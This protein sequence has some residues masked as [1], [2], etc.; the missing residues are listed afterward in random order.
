MTIIV[1]T[2]E[3]G[4]Y[5]TY[6]PDGPAF[7]YEQ[8]SLTSVKLMATV[9]APAY[10]VTAQQ[11]NSSGTNI[12]SA[13]TVNATALPVAVTGLV[14]GGIYNFKIQGKN[15]SQLGNSQTILQYKLSSTSLGGT[16]ISSGIDPQ[17]LTSA[18][19]YFEIAYPGGKKNEFAVA[20]KSFDGVNTTTST[21][22]SIS[23]PTWAQAILKSYTPAYYTFGTSIFMN[24]AQNETSQS[25]GLG[26]FLSNEGKSGYYVIVESTASSGAQGRKSVRIV[27]STTSGLKVLAD[28]QTAKANIFDGIYGGNT[29]NLDIKVKVSGDAVNIT[30]FINGFKIIASDT[31]S[32]TAGE[33]LN[34][35]IA[36]TQAI[37][38][39]SIKGKVAFD[40]VYAASIDEARY[41][42]TDVD[43]NLYKGQFSNDLLDTAYGNLMYNSNNASDAIS[44]YKTKKVVEE[45]G[46]VVREIAYV[47]QRFENP[48]FPIGWS[49]GENDAVNIIGSK[50][51]SFGAEAFILNN[52]S[53]TVPL[54][55]NGTNMLMVFGNSIGDSGTLVYKTDEESD[56]SNQEPVIFESQWLQTEPDVKNLANWI[57]SVV[58]NKSKLVSFSTFGNPLLSVGDM[59]SIKYSYQ[60]ISETAKFIITEISHS[61]QDGLETSIVCRTL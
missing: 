8:D 14:A 54:A 25:G 40:Y 55:D 22:S 27:K 29:Y 13:I 51:S 15:G 48:S 4:N 36:P 32:Y 37:G 44:T 17:K 34:S 30:V 3:D 52:T 60:G 58:I 6:N 50:L 47:K 26:F 38:V 59:I 10:V 23:A 33:P 31:N 12:G 7:V 35:I 21:Q 16:V 43:I 57:K 56:F 28:T 49:S 61:Y 42:S 41:L 2:G 11:V 20:Y 9:D 39:M 45:F 19:S 46:S 5:S 24:N 18:K 1:E 53:T